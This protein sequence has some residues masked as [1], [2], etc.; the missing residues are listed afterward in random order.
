MCVGLHCKLCVCVCACVRLC[1]CKSSLVHSAG[2]SCRQDF[3][4]FHRKQ[5]GGVWEAWNNAVK[6]STTQVREQGSCESEGREESRARPITAAGTTCWLTFHPMAFVQN[7]KA[8][9]AVS[10]AG[11]HE[12]KTTQTMFKHELTPEFQDMVLL[13]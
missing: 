13:N 1:V 10:M 9:K 3:L 8:V 7:S 4:F 11:T 6:V 5:N 12:C 2:N